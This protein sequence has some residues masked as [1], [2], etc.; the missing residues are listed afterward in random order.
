MRFASAVPFLFALIGVQVF[1]IPIELILLY[2]GIVVA[3]VFAAAWVYAW[4]WVG[5][6]YEFYTKHVV[7]YSIGYGIGI[8]VNLVYVLP[9]LQQNGVA[10]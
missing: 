5:V 4:I 10:L 7:V 3:A 9:W 6:R 8:A 1:L 2:L